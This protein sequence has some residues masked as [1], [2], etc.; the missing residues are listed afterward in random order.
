MDARKRYKYRLTMQKGD[1][2]GKKRVRLKTLFC[3]AL[4]PPIICTNFCS[5]IRVFE[6]GPE[7][8]AHTKAIEGTFK[9]VESLSKHWEKIYEERENSRFNHWVLGQLSTITK[10]HAE[11]YE[12]WMCT[13]TWACILC[14][15][16]LFSDKC[17][18]RAHTEIEHTPQFVELE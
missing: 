4:A 3:K 16:S 13:N 14:P 5:S 9:F 2:P 11:L 1:L 10:A 12:A 15:V 17:L 18:L 8:V 6:V 7:C